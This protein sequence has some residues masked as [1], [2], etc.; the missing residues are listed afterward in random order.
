MLQ[1]VTL[2]GNNWPIYKKKMRAMLMVRE[3]LG[4]IDTKGV[5]VRVQTQAQ[6]R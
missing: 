2:K 1:K 5:R 6:V 3:L 4:A